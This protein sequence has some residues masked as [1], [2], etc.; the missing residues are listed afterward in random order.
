MLCSHNEKETVVSIH[1]IS[2]ATSLRP[3]KSAFLHTV[4]D[5]A[6]SN[7]HNLVLSKDRNVQARTESFEQSPTG[8]EQFSITRKDSEVWKEC[9]VIDENNNLVFKNCEKDFLSLDDGK[10]FQKRPKS[11]SGSPVECIDALKYQ[12]SPKSEIIFSTGLWEKDNDRIDL[13]RNFVIETEKC[14]QDL[15]LDKLDRD[16]TRE[17]DYELD[18]ASVCNKLNGISRKK[19]SET[20]QFSYELSKLPVKPKAD[21]I[22]D[23][24]DHIPQLKQEK[25]FESLIREP[26]FLPLKMQLTEIVKV[27]KL[28]YQVD[29]V[30]VLK[31]DPFFDYLIK[32]VAPW[33]KS[34]YHVQQVTGPSEGFRWI[35][36]EE[37]MKKKRR[38]PAKI[39]GMTEIFVNDACVQATILV[40]EHF[41][42][43]AFIQSREHCDVETGSER[44]FSC[45]LENEDNL[46]DLAQGANNCWS[47]KKPR[48]VRVPIS[49]DVIR[50]DKSSQTEENV[51]PWMKVLCN[52]SESSSFCSSLHDGLVA[53]RILPV[54]KY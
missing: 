47:L 17:L 40:K 50:V 44:F 11:F 31:E 14:H 13:N 32:A 16:S 38:V 39:P 33:K 34:C 3:L 2:Q 48:K 8:D 18:S 41:E 51:R 20:S 30:V 9:F 6:K 29:D 53:P 24:L 15:N 25:D 19:S 42:L 10:K 26:V 28:R 45:H 35:A 4:I 43:L 46:E 12:L 36:D 1:D 7:G 52:D 54:E 49:C 23:Y 5:E 27:R 22:S 37:V 21:I